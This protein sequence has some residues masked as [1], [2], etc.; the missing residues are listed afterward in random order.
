MIL[1]RADGLLRPDMS[2][3]KC[4]DGLFLT[5]EFTASGIVIL[6]AAF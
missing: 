3:L 1:G 4:G 6:P 5:L 2:A